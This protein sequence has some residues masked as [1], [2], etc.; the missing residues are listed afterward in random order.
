MQT[1][2]GAT[3]NLEES[4]TD[5][6]VNPR[7]CNVGSCPQ[8]DNQYDSQLGT[9][10]SIG[11]CVQGLVPKLEGTRAPAMQASARRGNRWYLLHCSVG[12]RQQ[13]R[14]STAATQDV[15][16]S[17]AAARPRVHCGRPTVLRLPSHAYSIGCL[18]AG[19]GSNIGV[20]LLL[21]PKMY[22][23]AEPQPALEYIAL[24]A[25]ASQRII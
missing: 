15:Q 8:S 12:R 2:N 10:L 13:R 20:N 4:R 7:L 19:V 5:R 9:L 3:E 21:S 25:V 16:R 24:G 22:F 17:S 1:V 18:T 14:A 23:E 6:L 11:L